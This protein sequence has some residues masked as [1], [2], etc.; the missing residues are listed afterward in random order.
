MSKIRSLVIVIIVLTLQF[1]FSNNAKAGILDWFT[2]DKSNVL[3]SVYRIWSFDSLYNVIK[4][5]EIEVSNDSVLA[6][7]TSGTISQAPT[8]VLEVENVNA[9]Y[10]RYHRVSMTAY[11]STPDQTDS[12]PFITAA[13][14]YVRDGIVA[15]N[16]INPDTGRR[17]AFGTRIRIPELY[18]DKVFI[19][20]DRM[21]SRYTNRVDIWFSTRGEA[22]EFGRKTTTI[23][24]LL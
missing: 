13:N 5:P 21:N 12:T 16:L 11:S 3:D 8:S 17:Y 6:T 23:E 10:V 1:S 22:L 14:T 9:S 7:M 19:V 20:E 4:L 15:T 18:G 24:V 2:P